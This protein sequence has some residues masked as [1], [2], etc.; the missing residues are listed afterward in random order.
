MTIDDNNGL[1]IGS[2]AKKY[3]YI[4]T[5]DGS[6]LVKVPKSIHAD[7][8]F[9]E[10]DPNDELS[11]FAAAC[12]KTCNLAIIGIRERDKK[13][14]GCRMMR[15]E[16]LSPAAMRKASRAAVRAGWRD[17]AIAVNRE[18]PEKSRDA[19]IKTFD[20]NL[21]RLSILVIGDA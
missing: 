7:E 1:Y 8:L 5:P 20:I 2:S 21:M 11:E 13:V 12:L 19:A 6:S 16:K 17:V 4:P 14:L 10:D 3:K 15:T 18:L 9:A